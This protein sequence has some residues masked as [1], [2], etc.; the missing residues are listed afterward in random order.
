MKHLSQY[1]EE[2]TG[3]LYKKLGA[4]YA[5]NPDQFNKEKDKNLE[6]VNMG[7]GLLC[8]EKNV[9]EFVEKLEVAIDTAVR[10]DYSDN[11]ASNIISR[12]YFNYETH[13][14][15]DQ[16]DLIESLEIYK[17][18]F[19]KDFTDAVIAKAISKCWSKALKLDMF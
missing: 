15:G 16:D 6:Y 11:G 19:P 14:S 13:I 18:K 7:H 4:F 12:N 17:K 9:K 5:F 3:A 1:I 8:P 2:E 10:N